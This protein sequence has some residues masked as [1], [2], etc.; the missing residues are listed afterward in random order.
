MNLVK[1][2]VVTAEQRKDWHSIGRVHCIWPQ[3]KG[4][5]KNVNQ[6]L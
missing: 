6:N 5:S 4:S 2:K 1:K 3:K